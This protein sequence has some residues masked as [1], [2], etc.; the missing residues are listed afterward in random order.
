MALRFVT[1]RFAIFFAASILTYGTISNASAGACDSDIDLRKNLLLDL[2]SG[3]QGETYA[4]GY[5]AA[6]TELNAY[7]RRS[8][9]HE[10]GALPVDAIALAI[11]LA[12]EKHPTRATVLELT[13]DPLSEVEGHRGSLFCSILAFART[14]GVCDPQDPRVLDRDWMRK[15]SDEALSLYRVLEPFSRKRDAEKRSA[16]DEVVK[17]VRAILET[18]D[19]APSIKSVSESIWENRS[20]PYRVLRTLLYP[21]C[22][23]ESYRRSFAELPSCHENWFLGSST[24]GMGSDLKRAG[25]LAAAIHSRLD[26]PNPLPI[27]VMHCFQVLREGHAYDGSR[28]W[29]DNCVL[30]YVNVIGRRKKGGVCQFLLRNSYDP[31]DEFAISKDWQRDGPDLWVDAGPFTRSA[32]ALHDLAD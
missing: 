2:P 25:K 14:A 24:L 4:C 29:R 22:A 5:F 31:N 1:L 30:H 9:M 10:M 28:I 13:S 11:D 18:V 19:S 15:R 12:I 7:R 8:A 23:G 26:A 3:D 21:Q 17:A 6:A 32:F 16:L 27:P 20:E